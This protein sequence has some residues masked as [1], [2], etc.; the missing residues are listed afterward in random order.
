MRDEGVTKYHVR[1]LPA[2]PPHADEVQRLIACRDRLFAQGLIGVYPDGIGYGNVSEKRPNTRH[3]FI[4]GTQTG[5]LAHL[6]NTHISCVTGYSIA[7]NSVEC[8][9]EVQASSE[10]LTHAAIYELGDAIGAVIHIHHAALWRLGQL[11]LPTSRADVPYGTPAM[12]RE[13]RRLYEESNLRDRRALIMAGH[14]EGC[15][16]FGATLAD[17]EA[18]LSRVMADILPATPR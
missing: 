1:F 6:T 18:T 2:A 13:I 17:A 14:D 7:E 4:T 15:I 5:H 8:E 16:T 10:S 12:A 3:F 9:G 11:S